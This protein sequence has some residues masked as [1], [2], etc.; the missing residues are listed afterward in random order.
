M[1]YMMDTQIRSSHVDGCMKSR[2]KNMKAQISSNNKVNDHETKLQWVKNTRT[3]KENIAKVVEFDAECEQNGHR[4]ASRYSALTILHR[5]CQF[6]GDKQFKEFTKT[7]IVSFLDAV[8][9]RKFEDRRHRAK[10]NPDNVEKQMANSSMNLMKLRVKQFFQWLYSMEKDQYPENVRW[11]K[12]KSIGP[13]R[14]IS[15]E[16]LP[17]PEEVKRM[18]EC[19]E[20]PRNR[21]L[22]SLMAE[23]GT[24]IGE[25]STIRLKDICWNDNGFILTIRAA[26]SKST[27]SRRIPLCA[28]AEDVKRWIND[29]HPF[30][31]DPEAPLFISFVDRRTPKT[32]LKVDGIA[33]IVR[34]VATRAG[35]EKRIHIH[36]HKFRH[37]RA[38]QLAE[39]GWN[40]P[41]LRQYF[42]WTKTSPMP[43]I[44]IHMS[45]KS[46]INRYYQ[47]YGK[48]VP[49][50]A[51]EQNV[52]EPKA[53]SKC[54]TRNPTGYRFCLQ[55]NTLLEKEEQK[56]IEDKSEVKDALNFVINDPELSAKL[57]QLLQ[58]ARVKE[59][60]QAPVSTPIPA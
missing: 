1:P 17:K 47:M 29:Y 15:P 49:Q 9:N 33:A 53:C 16:E 3:L 34:N 30:K 18:I 23:S 27:F 5:L 28:C 45:Q 8:K 51:K 57:S 13:E 55:C 43:T 38:S 31:N 46:M 21:A 52:G 24:R 50:E 59:E 20:H 25:I 35:V 14:E 22:I 40:E 12:I 32:N 58:E 39:L 19:T 36:P 42:G 54:G 48:A 60:L 56:C 4:V 7:D 26:M 37:F 11:I 6:A 41:M 44:Y 2:V 10:A